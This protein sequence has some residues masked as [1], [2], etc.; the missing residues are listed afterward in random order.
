MI[1]PAEGIFVSLAFHIQNA[2]CG[3]T[4]GLAR[5]LRKPAPRFP[6]LFEGARWSMLRTLAGSVLDLK[7]LLRLLAFAIFRSTLAR[8]ILAM[9]L[10]KEACCARR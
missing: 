1:K 5:A 10:S 3:G 4:T 8:C 7:M 2:A 6:L 9:C